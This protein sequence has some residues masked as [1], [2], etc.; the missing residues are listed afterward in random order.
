MVASIKRLRL[1]YNLEQMNADEVIRLLPEKIKTQ[2]EIEEENRIKA[3][4]AKEK[5]AA[6]LASLK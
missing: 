5:E 1:T 6:I 4:K 2:E 3:E